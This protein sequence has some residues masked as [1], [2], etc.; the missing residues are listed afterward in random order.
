MDSDAC[1]FEVASTQ[2][3]FFTRVQALDC[4]FT[5]DKLAYHARTG[6]FKIVHR[7][8]YRYRDYPSSP[9]EPMVAA[10]LAVGKDKS[11]ISHESALSLHELSDVIPNEVHLTVPRTSHNQ[12]KLRNVRIHTTTR[13]FGPSDIVWK[14][15]MLVTS[16]ARTVVDAS[17]KGTGPEQI[18]MAV[19][20]ALTRGLSTPRRF[21]EAASERSLRVRRLVER[22]LDMSAS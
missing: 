22:A 10:W 2:H 4:G 7:G 3:G 5:D 21:R 11:V 9:F 13:T 15:G 8:V 14:E 1:V 20:H 18:E 6:R 16:V 17:E 19:H 12:P